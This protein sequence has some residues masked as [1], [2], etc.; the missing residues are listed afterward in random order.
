MI[1]SRKKKRG[2]ALNQHQQEPEE[3]P[4]TKQRRFHFHSYTIPPVVDGVVAASKTPTSDIDRSSEV[5]C[6][7]VKDNSA[8]FP[9]GTQQ[10][11]QE[12]HVPDCRCVSDEMLLATLQDRAASKKYATR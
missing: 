11:Q 1:N 8:F 4:A 7:V 10:D 9:P 3:G 6:E 5:L 12:L 2:N